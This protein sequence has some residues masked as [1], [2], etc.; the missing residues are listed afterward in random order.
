MRCSQEDLMG[1][2]ALSIGYEAE[3]GNHSPKPRKPDYYKIVK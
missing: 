3:G 1:I 2:G